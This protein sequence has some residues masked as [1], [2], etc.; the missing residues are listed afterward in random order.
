MPQLQKRLK[1]RGEGSLATTHRAPGRLLTT[2]VL[3][4]V[5]GMFRRY[6][7]SPTE[8]PSP[9]YASDTRRTRVHL[10]QRSWKRTTPPSGI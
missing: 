9:S 6:L 7:G 3:A 8:A 4:E 10:E 1:A 5:K 2:A